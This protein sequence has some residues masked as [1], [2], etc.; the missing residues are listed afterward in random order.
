MAIYGPLMCLVAATFAGPVVAHPHV[1][2]D[3]GVDFVVENDQLAALRVTWVYDEFETL[4]ILSSHDLS[5]NLNGGLGEEDRAA[6]EQYR[7]DWPSDFDGSAHL[8][9]DNQQIALQWPTGLKADVLDGRLKI[10]FTRELQ[11]TV[12][13]SDLAASV[14]FYESTYFFAFSI[15][16]TPEIFGSSSAC[17]AEVIKHDPTEQDEQVQAA[18]A[19][20]SREET[21]SIAN[22]GALFAD[23]IELKCD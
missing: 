1:F 8:K 7:S 20:L 4:Y 18:L 19:K 13:A 14:A 22:V 10:T 23:R 11:Q 2:V 5:L 12:P 17:S 9:I 16:Q 15:T 6:L 21:S 3:G